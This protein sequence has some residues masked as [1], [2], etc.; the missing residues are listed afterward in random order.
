MERAIDLG[1]EDNQIAHPHRVQKIQ[2]IHGSCNDLAV[3]VPVRG[4]GS[5]HVDQVHDSAAQD[6]PK[7]V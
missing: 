7:K 2:M 1:F 3:A 4:N 6:I 5:R